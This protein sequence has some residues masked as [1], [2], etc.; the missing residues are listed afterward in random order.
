MKCK[1][2]GANWK[3]NNVHPDFEVCPICSID[4][5]S[6]RECLGFNEIEELVLFLINE[7]KMDI[8]DNSNIILAYIGDLFPERTIER[9]IIKTLI[10]DGIAT[11]INNFLNKKLSVQELHK[12]VENRSYSQKDRIIASIDYICG[13]NR[14][15]DDISTKEFYLKQLDN[16]YEDRYKIIALKKA[17]LIDPTDDQIITELAEQMYKS[18]EIDE[19]ILL[20]RRS[21]ELGNSD[22]IVKLALHSYRKK[23]KEEYFELMH[24]AAELGNRVACFR[25]YLNLYSEETTKE[26]AMEYLKAAVDKKYVPAMYEYAIHLL[27]GDSV[28]KDNDA[29]ILLLEECASS[30]Y[31]DAICKLKFVSSQKH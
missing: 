22:S 8:C 17:N 30:G 21:A 18:K 2:C 13:I 25:E 5:K 20:L 9:E 16:V 24:K 26:A 29:A 1:I 23:D 27:H 11:N 6:H 28:P 12:V 3:L 10:E 31:D 19:Y 15:G 4:F 7:N 14:S